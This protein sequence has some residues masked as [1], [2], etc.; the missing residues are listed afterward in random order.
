MSG[1]AKGQETRVGLP[2]YDDIKKGVVE[3][4]LKFS[5]P[6]MSRI[7]KAKIA[8]EQAAEAAGDKQK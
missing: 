4:C 8:E 7:L 2:P 6:A 3:N 1:T 5:P